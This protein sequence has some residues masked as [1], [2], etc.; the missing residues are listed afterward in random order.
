M[1]CDSTMVTMALEGLERVLRVGESRMP[2]TG[3]STGRAAM[4]NPYAALLSEAR[5]ARS[6]SLEATI[7]S[8]AVLASER[9]SGRQASRVWDQH[10]VTCAICQSSS[11]KTSPN[12]EYCEECR[13]VVCS[14][15]DCSVYHLSYQEKMWDDVRDLIIR[16]LLLALLIG[17][18]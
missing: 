11:A 14:N 1:L 18:V 17:P 8:S 5:R 15:C 3:K 2:K 12:T 7:K 13:G 9:Q 6:T 4:V 16:T 10:F